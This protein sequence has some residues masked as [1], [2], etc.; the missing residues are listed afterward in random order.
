MTKSALIS[1]C[2]QLM[3]LSYTFKMFS[4]YF[5]ALILVVPVEYLLTLILLLQQTEHVALTLIFFH[6][7]ILTN[8]KIK[9]YY[10]AE[11]E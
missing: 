1:Q 10:R 4:F 6:V 2:L 8:K 9:Y 5:K 7:K 11:R 3:E